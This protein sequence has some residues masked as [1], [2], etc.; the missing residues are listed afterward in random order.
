MYRRFSDLR[1]CDS[2]W[3]AEYIAT[4][5]YPIAK[6]AYKRALARNKETQ[7]QKKATKRGRSVTVS[8]PT[9]KKMRANDDEE[10]PDEAQATSDISTSAAATAPPLAASPLSSV[11]S[12]MLPPPSTPL[13]TDALLPALSTNTVP[14]P[15]PTLHP[16]N[17]TIPIINPLA[18]HRGGILQEASPIA[19]TLPSTLGNPVSILPGLLAD[20][21]A[22]K[23]IEQAPVPT[24][25]PTFDAPT[26]A[27]PAPTAS[28]LA[29]TLLVPAHAPPGPPT[30]ASAPSTQTNTS[31][32]NKPGLKKPTASLA[33]ANLFARDWC[34]EM[35]WKGRVDEFNAA[36]ASL[37]KSK[38]DEYKARSIKEKNELK[39]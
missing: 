30:P 5:Q 38:K 36:W 22:S 31:T 39:A 28:N 15:L 33:P 23:D 35:N 20:P 17:V 21:A 7:Q 25:T 16:A 10:E 13:S 14:M 2:H 18:N 19:P 11:S 8:T 1:L 34:K 27:I 32:K 24:P 9:T 37:S 29:P 3:K 12:N 6:K 4:K 26:Q